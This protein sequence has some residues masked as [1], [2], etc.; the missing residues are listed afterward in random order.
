MIP[1]AKK[2]LLDE[3]VA[4]RYSPP[5]PDYGPVTGP[6]LEAMLCEEDARLAEEEAAEAGRLLAERRQQMRQQE[7]DKRVERAR[8]AMGR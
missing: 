3:L 2:R 6:Q 1:S 5:V 7:I 4:E 8:K